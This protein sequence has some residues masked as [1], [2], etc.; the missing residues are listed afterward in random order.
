ML[1]AKPDQIHEITAGPY[2]DLQHVL[3]IE[4]RDFLRGQQAGDP[5]RMPDGSWRRPRGNICD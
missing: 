5:Y 4:M 1:A 2:C 3:Q